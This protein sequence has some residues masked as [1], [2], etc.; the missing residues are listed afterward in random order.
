[1]SK[2]IGRRFTGGTGGDGYNDHGLL[3]G[4]L[5]DDHPQYLITTA[6]RTLTSPASG[7]SK[8]GTG[9]G[10]VFTLVNAGTG[11]ALF[12]Q[13]TG[14]TST[15]DAAVDIDN[16]ANIG[17]GLSVFS[18]NTS[19]G[20]PLVQ[21]SVSDIQFD[22]P[23]LSVEHADP[24]GLALQILGD[25]YIACQLEV[26]NGLVLSNLEANP[27]ELGKGGI[28]IKNDEFYFVDPSGTERTWT[29]LADGGDTIIVSSGDGYYPFIEI[30]ELEVSGDGSGTLGNVAGTASAASITRHNFNQF[31]MGKGDLEIKGLTLRHTIDGEPLPTITYTVLKNATLI[32]S[33]QSTTV[34]TEGEF[35]FEE[36]A[37]ATETFI[38]GNRKDGEVQFTTGV[39]DFDDP[40]FTSTDG[41][42]DGY[43]Y[44]VFEGSHTNDT[45]TIVVERRTL[46]PNI[47]SIEFEYPVC[48]FTG[49]QQTA[50]RAGQSFEVT[51]TTST[52]GYAPAT[53]VDVDS[54]DAIQ[55]TVALTETS[56]GSG[57]WTGTVVA[58]TGQPNGF[59]DINVTAV[60]AL[61]NSS[62]ESTTTVG[63][64]LVFFDNDFPVIE[65]FEESLDLIY[66]TGQFCLKFGESVDAYMTASDFT[67]ILYSSPNGRFTIPN[68][69]TYEENKKITWDQGS[70]GIEENQGCDALTVTN[71][72]IRARKSSNCSETTRNIQVRLDDTPPRVSSIRWRRDNTG[73]YNLTSPVLC[74]GTHGIRFVFD[75]CLSEIPEFTIQDA[76]KGTL[77]P[78][79]GSTPGDTFTATLTISNPSDTSGCTE[80]VLN[81]AINC[82]HKLPL[83]A[84]PINGTDEEYCIDVV[85]P[86]IDFVQIDVD[87]LDGYLNDGYDGYNVMDDDI[88]NQDNTG[89]ACEHDFSSGVQSITAN[90][91]LTRH[92]ENVFVTVKMNAPIDAG[93]SCAF[94][95]SPWG[96]GASVSIPQLDTFQYQGPFITNLGSTR[97]DDQGR[98]IGRA[99]VFHATGDNATVTEA[100]TCYDEAA[101]EDVLS[102]NGIDNIASEIAF[103]S[104]GTTGGAFQVSSDSFRAFMINRRIRIVDDNSSAIYRTVRGSEIDGSNGTIFCDGGDLS[105]FTVAQNARAVPL[106]VT[107]AEVQAWDANNGLIAY[108]DDGAFTNLTLVDMAN[109]E[110]F[111]QHLSDDQLIENNSGTPGVDLFRANFWGSKISVP[112]TNGGTEANPTAEM[113]S[114]YVWRSKRIRL[115]TNPTGVQGTNIRFMVFGFAAGTTYRNVNITSPGDWDQNSSRFDL[116]NND[117]Q[118][119]IRISV[120]DPYAAIPPHTLA[121]WYST[122]DFEV[123]PQ[124]G[125]KFGKNKDINITFDPPSTDVID[126]DIYIEVTLTTNASGKAPQIDM[127]GMAYLT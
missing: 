111:S 36:V 75:D 47:L 122:T 17:R 114:R 104:D 68:P 88:D 1:M 96:A 20:L 103:T 93:D 87:V 71:F 52:D 94:D 109:P 4:L 11:S 25:A 110:A 34:L 100:S 50:V 58:R 14:N 31:L 66:P 56:P 40:E 115:T 61:S 83:D 107:D 45:K 91:I 123:S 113:N 53:S 16:S 108:V 76:N 98:A 7:I 43:F 12:V 21:F 23:I 37:A 41:N 19:P 28:Y 60:D 89:Q 13:Q 116:G 15:A 22:E 67:E 102:A 3:T 49:T 85:P 79:S 30:D 124:S 80:L 125:F 35:L 119:D 117:N 90:D 69:T 95:A 126:K 24:C 127:I 46:G 8:T 51:V 6:V 10:D 105:Q 65:S 63:D 84:D 121:N 5:D 101:N 44:F 120:D 72:R 2:F 62:S 32:D 86:D 74:E 48:S 97:V 78:L 42:P 59:A 81:T 106:G 9:A 55:S 112:N 38:S 99:S 118:I 39:F 27:F 77:S 82:S 92:G 57:I 26:G 18:S 29:E 64:A 54:G 70:S 73:P 33:L